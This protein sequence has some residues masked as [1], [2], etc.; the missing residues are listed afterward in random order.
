[1]LVLQNAPGGELEL[2]GLKLSPLD[3]NSEGTPGGE[4]VAVKFELTVTMF[5]TREGLRG[6]VSYNRDLFDVATIERLMRHWTRLLEAV[7]GDATQRLSRLPMMTS[8]ERHELLVEWNDTTRDYRRE[9][10]V[11]QL[12]EQQVDRDRA[13]VALQAGSGAE[14]GSA[15]VSPA[16][17]GSSA[18]G[19]RAGETPAVP[20][21]EVSYGE[22]NER[23]NRL[24]HYLRGR[25]VGT[26]TLVGVYLER[27][28]ELVVALL[29]VVKAGGAYVPLD[30]QYPSERLSFILEQTKAPV[31]LTRQS[32]SHGLPQSTGLIVCLD[33]E[34][35]AAIAHESPA[36]P[37]H[38]VEREQLVY[39]LYT[40]G[41]TGQPKGVA[42][43][44]GGLVNY[45]QW[46]RAEYLR[47]GAGAPLHSTIGFDLTVTSLYLPLLAGERV[48]L[49]AEEQGIEGLRETLRHAQDFSLVKLTPAHLQLLSEQ[50]TGAEAQQWTRTLVIGG[51][52]LTAEQVSFWRTQA[53]QVRLINEYGPTETVVG[54]AVYEVTPETTS[55]GTIPIGRPI[56][57]TELYLLDEQLEAVPVGAVGELYIGGEGVARGYLGRPE[58]TAAQ[59]VPH[60]F[61]AD[62][63]AR[64]Y[65]SGDLARYRP[66]GELEFLGRADGQVTV[67][68][69]RVES[70]EVEAALRS[71]EGVQEAV[72]VV[73]E[74]GGGTPA[75]AG[76][77]GDKRLVAY[78]VSADGEAVGSGQLREWLRQRLPDYMVPSVFV[79]LAE[80]PLTPNGK[81]DRK[82]LP[83]PEFGGA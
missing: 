81:V 69:Y 3:G 76:S 23:A 67:R 13:A 78:V 57:N 38:E 36:N 15:G 61:A 12:F 77:E 19:I 72:V 7:V 47:G 68:G 80:L 5:E 54:C 8:A 73:H 71:H 41:S 52:A 14:A 63:G 32:L 59:F 64:L 65:R 37:E 27:S 50:V 29:A 45:L 30:P 44:H 58:L 25:G 26:E 66:N 62:R 4:G 18:V 49:V 42:V 48:L 46:A 1:M 20:G 16:G 11:A 17:D 51:E 79:P 6:S 34:D 39:V 9:L 24:G 33:G 53:P 28:V 43:T 60:P 70:G 75:V 55:S 2:P 74:R 21:T 83:E 40:S 31:V 22:L 10:S 56:A 35:A 82:A